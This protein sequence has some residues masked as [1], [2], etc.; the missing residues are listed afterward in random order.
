MKSSH[1]TPITVDDT[2]TTDVT[3]TND[4]VYTDKKS[5]VQVLPAPICFYNNV[6]GVSRI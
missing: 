5:D 3:L 2:D 6:R 1:F 4:D